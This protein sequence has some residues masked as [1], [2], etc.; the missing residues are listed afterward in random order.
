ME[1]LS[2]SGGDGL[3]HTRE[4]ERIKEKVNIAIGKRECGTKRERGEAIMTE[5]QR[6]QKYRHTDTHTHKHRLRLR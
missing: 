6:K 3:G 2:C 4:T 5:R 1:I